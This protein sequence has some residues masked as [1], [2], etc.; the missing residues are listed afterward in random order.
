MTRFPVTAAAI[1][2]S[3]AALASSGCVSN[4][5]PLMM[6]AQLDGADIEEIVVLPVLDSRPSRFDH[7]QVARNVAE[8][9]V[10]YLRER[11]YFTLTA[12]TF[13]QP[14][15]EPFDVYLATP[16]QLSALA[17]ED[18][19]YFLLVSVERLE[20]GVD[21]GGQTYDAKLAAVMVDKEK[22][23]VVWRDVATASSSLSGVLTVFSKGSRQ[24]EAA[25]NA[26]RALVDTLPDR[27]P[28]PKKR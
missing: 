4:R 1:A 17:P 25:V 2:I 16:D 28:E 12:D 18:S 20:P 21:E 14:P 26:S 11:G 15:P 27:N 3:L 6:D 13:R 19:R 24:Y 7:V 22:N 23:R 9:T 10:R 8:A 5:T